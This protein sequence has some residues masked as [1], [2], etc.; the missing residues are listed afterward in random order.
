MGQQGVVKAR[1]EQ[2]STQNGQEVEPVFAYVFTM[3]FA[4]Q[5]MHLTV[6]LISIAPSYHTIIL[7]H[8]VGCAESFAQVEMRH[9]SCQG[10]FVLC[11]SRAAGPSKWGATGALL[12]HQTQRVP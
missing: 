10:I 12:V 2:P 9:T 1:D 7:K 8:R 4:S 6:H 11:I 5:K 3:L